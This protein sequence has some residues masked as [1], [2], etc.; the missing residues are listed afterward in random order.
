MMS[1]GD[2]GDWEERFAA[3]SMGIA[4]KIGW[5]SFWA[6]GEKKLAIVMSTFS[7]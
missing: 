1:A 7:I 5:E 6:Y 3:E 2:F 4:N